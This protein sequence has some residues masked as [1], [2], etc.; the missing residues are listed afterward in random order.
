MVKRLLITIL[1]LVSVC[2]AQKIDASRLKGKV[3]TSVVITGTPVPLNCV[4]IS[5]DTLT[6]VPVSCNLTVDVRD[7]IPGYSM[8]AKCDNNVTDDTAA[9]QGI[10]N[11]YGKGGPG[12][13]GKVKLAFPPGRS[14]KQTNTLVFEGANGVGIDIEGVVSSG[15]NDTQLAW[16]GPNF[17]TQ[18]LLLSCTDCSVNNLTFQSSP[19]GGGKAQ[20]ALW[21][22]ASNTVTQVAYASSSIS[23]ASNVVTATV[24]TH[25]I[26]PGRIVKVAGVADASFNG[27]FRV[28]Y[29]NDDTHVS[30]IQG[31]VDATSSGGTVTNY[32]SAITNHVKMHSVKVTNPKAVSSS[33]SAISWSNPTL[34]ITTATPHFFSL[35]DTIIVR[36]VTDIA[37]NCAYTVTAIPTST[38][39][40]AVVLPGTGCSPTPASSSGGTVLS[41]STG[42]RLGHRDTVTPQVAAIQGD[43]LFLQGDQLGGSVTAIQA[44]VGGNVKNFSFSNIEMNGFRYGLSG[45]NSGSFN[46]NKYHAGGMTPDSKALLATIDFVNNGSAATTIDGAETEASNSRF[47]VSTGTTGTL[48]IKGLT[49][50]S[51][52]PLDDNIIIWGGTLELTNSGLTNNRSAGSTPYLACG[53]LLMTAANNCSLISLN[54]FYANTNTGGSAIAPKWVPL[55][56]LSGNT[57]RQAGGFYENKLVNITS[58]GDQGSTTSTFGNGT[59][60]ALNPVQPAVNTTSNCSNS[61]SPAV[62]ANSVRGSVVIAAAA[63]TVVVNTTSVS[64]ISQ[65]WVTFDESLGTKLGVTCNNAGA[66]EAAQ[67]FV[68]AR[69]AGTS[70]TIKTSVAPTTNPACLSFGIDN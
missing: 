45:L 22:D 55:H 44:D 49:F 10:L 9:I 33:I 65:I 67:Y 25:V 7:P 41:G 51:A 64:A 42:I 20:N 13:V 39:A 26:T 5:S 56:D 70:F 19:T 35:S 24:A 32:H 59:L 2:A 29:T 36:G 23:R 48:A 40:T 54:N 46:V 57:F 1:A 28:L 31:G 62:C 47:W 21:W 60:G 58:I 11:Y 69:T 53:S 38:T 17:G 18:L 37:Y 43:D 50:Q 16:F 66:S 3:P 14:C 61:A 6:F 30:W 68:S 8:G 27:S 63:T 15:G 12:A 52:G 4:S 34:S